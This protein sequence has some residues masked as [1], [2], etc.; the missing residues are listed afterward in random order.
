MKENTIVHC[1]SSIM[2]GII[3]GVLRA[4]HILDT[5]HILYHVIL[6]ILETSYVTYPCSNLLECCLSQALPNVKA[7]VSQVPQ[8]RRESSD[9]QSSK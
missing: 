6:T 1:E 4:R 3:N 9:L 7:D 2:L 5:L 8:S